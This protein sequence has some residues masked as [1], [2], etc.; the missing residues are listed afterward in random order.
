MK[1]IIF[2][3][4][5][6][7]TCWQANAQDYL[8]Q[9]NAC[10]EEGNY[11]C[12]KTNFKLFQILDGSDMST[13]IQKADECF[14]VLIAAD[15]YFREKEYKKASDRYK[16]VL[17]KN[18]KDLYAH[19]QYDA[20]M[21]QLN[22]PA[23]SPSVLHDLSNTQ[24]HPAEPEMVFVQGGTF[25]MGCTGEQ[26]KDCDKDEKPQHSVTLSDFYIGK[27]EVTQAQWIATM[28]ENTSKFKG[29]N[30]PV[31]RVSWKD[32]Q[33]FLRRLN[34]ATGKQYRLPTEAE[35]EYA[36]RGGNKNQGYMYSGSNNLTDVAWY[37][38]NSGSTT[39]PVGTKQA[40]ELGIYDMS[41]NVWEWCSDWYGSY[42]STAKTNPTGPSSGSY[43][44][45]RGGS[46][47]NFARD[48][49]VSIRNYGTPDYR[50]Y[51]IGFRLACSSE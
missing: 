9:A 51:F 5:F 48:V 20:C 7:F 3:T 25:W 6:L 21:A 13:Q 47:V 31:E 10:F 39:H 11:E 4:V 38:D 30:F 37:R 22:L 50:D 35:W 24:R 18:P 29:D 40:N 42:T 16:T 14:R 26:G 41:G 1:N 34:A 12:A 45:S 27:Y 44:V 2:F 23:P 32:V 19:K 17:E 8:Q 28:G 33:E 46:W 43:R 49:R 15:D 36:S